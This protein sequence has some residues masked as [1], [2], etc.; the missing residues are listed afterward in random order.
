MKLL[1][2]YWHI[3]DG[4]GHVEEV[5]GRA[6]S[7]SS[8]NSIPATATSISSGCPLTTPS[9]I[10]VG[11]YTMRNDSGEIFDDRHP[12]LL[13]GPAGQQAHRELDQ[14]LSIGS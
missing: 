10:M 14:D 9:G 4:A 12:R 5:P 1:S 13:A 11:R 8:R 6:W 2:R 7:A 3:T